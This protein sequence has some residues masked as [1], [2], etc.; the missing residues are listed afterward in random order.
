MNRARPADLRQALV[1]AHAMAENRVLFV[2]VPVRSREEWMELAQQSAKKMDD[3]V[4]EA[5]K[6]EV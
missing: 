1:A 2:P 6:S 5:E 4:D 3:I